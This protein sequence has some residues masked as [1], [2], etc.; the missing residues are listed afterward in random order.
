MRTYLENLIQEKGVELIDFIGIEGHYGLVWQD[1]VDYICVH[2]GDHHASIRDTL[3]KIDF[4]NGDVFHFLRHL[5]K[6]MLAA[7]GYDV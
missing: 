5:T 1:I 7:Q 6:G 3:V 4:Q 2:A